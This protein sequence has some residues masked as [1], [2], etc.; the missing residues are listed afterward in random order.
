MIDVGDSDT[1]KLRW[2]IRRRDGKAA[3][4]GEARIIRSGGYNALT[5]LNKRIEDVFTVRPRRH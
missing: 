5:C 1:D 2:G 4:L 3:T